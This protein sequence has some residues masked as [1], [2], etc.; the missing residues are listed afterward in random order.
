[1]PRR[2]DPRDPRTTTT[3][4][5][6]Q[7]SAS[8]QRRHPR[9]RLAARCWIA[10]EEHTVYLRVHDVSLGGLSV[11]ATVP[12]APHNRVELEL[13]LPTGARVRAIGEVVWVRGDGDSAPHP[14]APRMGARFLELLD[15]QAALERALDHV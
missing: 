12:F 9:V 3:T 14:E 1:M 13:E 4:L 15:G 5:V 10:D 8:N 11:R 7:P 2:L 6:E